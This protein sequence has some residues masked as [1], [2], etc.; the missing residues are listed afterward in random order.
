MSDRMELAVIGLI[1]TFCSALIVT[2]ALD[3]IDFILG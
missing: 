3:A 2:V 1:V